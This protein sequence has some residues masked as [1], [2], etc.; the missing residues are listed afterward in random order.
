M[1]EY[2]VLSDFSWSVNLYISTPF[3]SFP[4]DFPLG[5]NFLMTP[6]WYFLLSYFMVVL[7]L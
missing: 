6:V 4:Y 3:L 2:T 7:S 1:T 5:K